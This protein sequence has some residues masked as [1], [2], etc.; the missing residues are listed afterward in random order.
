MAGK[1]ADYVGAGATTLSVNL[2]N[3]TLEHTP[4][5]H[6]LAHLHRNVPG[7]LARV[8]QVLADR[9]VNVEG[10]LLT[11]RGELGYLLTDVRTDYTPD[12]IA[13]L[14]GLPETVSLRILD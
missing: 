7:V 11:T 12:V 2:P 8:N 13:E 3:V 9:Q 5:T 1:L 10:Q 14:E 6:R 4:G